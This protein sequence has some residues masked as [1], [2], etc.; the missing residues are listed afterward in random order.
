MIDIHLSLTGEGDGV[1]TSLVQTGG[2]AQA[3]D[4]RVMHPSSLESKLGGVTDRV[5]MRGAPRNQLLGR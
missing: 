4:R 3:H 5:L 2:G 1:L